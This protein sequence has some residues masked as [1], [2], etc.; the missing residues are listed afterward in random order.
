MPIPLN[1]DEDKLCEAALAI[2]GLTALGSHGVTRAWKGMD[3]DLLDLL[4]RKGWIENPV[5]KSKSVVL[6]EAGEQLAAEFLARHFASQSAEAPPD[7]R[8][9]VRRRKGTVA[10]AAGAGMV[11]Q[12]RVALLGTQPLVWRRVQVPDDYTF[13]DL[14]VALQDAMGWQDYHL[15]EF[16]F[17][18]RPSGELRIGIPDPDFPGERPCLAGWQVEL[19]QHIRPGMPAVAYLYDFGDGWEHE[20]T[21]EG[22]AARDKAARYPRCVDGA[23]ACPPEDCGGIDGYEEFVRAMRNPKHPRHKELREWFGGPFDPD[24][25]APATVMFDDP[26]RRWEAAFSGQD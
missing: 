16:R 26:R 14:H 24:A 11:H 19:S 9:S 18:T 17:P 5:G 13:W 7:G 8:S 15:H 23:A 4:F 2:L 21:Y 6:T 20:L 1:L 12:F 3:W 10:P 22:P 25:F